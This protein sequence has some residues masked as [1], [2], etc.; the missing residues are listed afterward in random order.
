MSE[1]NGYLV[2]EKR[3]EVNEKK[4]EGTGYAREMVPGP[5]P[6]GGTSPP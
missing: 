1:D 5:S 2:T 3:R 4:K 6:G